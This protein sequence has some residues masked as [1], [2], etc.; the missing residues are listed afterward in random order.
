MIVEVVAV[1]TELLLG[2]IVNSNGA[3]LGQ[4]FAENGFDSHYQVVVGDNFDR[5]VEAI[6][7]AIGRA[8]AVIL[9]GGIGPTQDD[10]TREAICAATGRPMVRSDDY[11]TY[12]RDRWESLGRIMPENNL[13]QADYPDGA[14]QLTNPKGTA[15]GIALNHEGTWIF[16]VPGVPA[17]MRLLITD[18][19]I[20][21]LREASGETRVL[22]S[23]VIRTWGR[24]ESQVA[25][26]LDE[27]F[28]ATTNPS[29]AFLA[30]AG[31]IKVRVATKAETTVE[32]EALIAPVEA[33]V[34]E[35]LGSSVFGTDEETIHTVVQSLLLE[36]GW[37][38]ATA[39]SATAGMLSAALT[40]TPGASAVVAG[41]IAAYTVEAK[42]ALLDVAPDL[43][44][45][46][47]VVSEP[48]ALA[49]AEGAI[50]RFGCEVG[51]GITGEAGPDAAEMSTGT[52]VIAVVTPEG[53]GA[54]TLQL[55]GDRERIRTYSTTAAMQLVR[56][57]VSGE[58]WGR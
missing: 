31:E 35:L 38:I 33:Q 57:A 10:V 1:G 21:R 47:G 24:S 8:D 36:R 27:L 12:L 56:L 45:D 34:R 5:M 28:Q 23:R 39:E 32:A 52:M 9:T 54:R 44:R 50:R 40:Q 25:E 58:W 48:T 22:V 42:A 4:Q 20:P 43:M 15:P 30:S 55:P 53:M 17:E 51:V 6:Q 3:F 46:E 41:G 49:M 37:R 16:A 19:V 14:D 18:H 7:T 29:V 26:M 11:A 13:R 2:Q